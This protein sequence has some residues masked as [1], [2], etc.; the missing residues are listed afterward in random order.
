MIFLSRVTSKFHGWPWKATGHLFHTRSSFVLHFKVMDA[1]KLELQPGKSQFCSKCVY[2]SVPCD[3]E[4]RRVTLKNNRSHLLYYNKP[5]ASFQ[6][7]R[8]IQIGVTV[9]KHSIGVKIGEFLSC[10][11]L[12]FD[13]WP[14]EATRHLFY[15]ASSSVPHFIAISEFK[16]DLP[17]GKNQF[18]SKAII[19]SRV[20]LQFDRWHWTTIAYLSYDTSSFVPHF[21]AIDETKLELQPGNAQFGSKAMFFLA[22]WPWNLTDG[23]QKQ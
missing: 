18:G 22:V 23:L 21:V 16:L 10:V 3:L 4:I 8:W 5:C 1:F 7:H 20:I 6:S 14:W 17:Y 12:K 2:F 15:A 19:F 13:G 11:S 9:R